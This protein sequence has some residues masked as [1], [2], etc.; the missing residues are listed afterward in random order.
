MQSKKK[1]NTKLINLLLKVIILGVFDY[2]NQFDLS[3]SFNSSKQ[4][5]FLK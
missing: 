4:K 3:V 2:N 5:Y 1:K